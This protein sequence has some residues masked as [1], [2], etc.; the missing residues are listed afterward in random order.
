MTTKLKG[1]SIERFRYL[2]FDIDSKAGE[3]QFHYA[4]DD[5]VA[6]VEKLLIGPYPTWDRPAVYEA[7]RLVYL[8]SGVS[9]YKAAAPPILDL[10][11]ISLRNGEPEFLRSFYLHGLGEFAFRNGLDL[12]GLTVEAESRSIA[13]SPTYGKHGHPLIPFGGGID[14][15]VSVEAVRYRFPNSAL[16]IVSPPGRR[17]SAIEEAAELTGLPVVRAQRSIDPILR[18]SDRLGFRNGH[19]PI[20]GIISAIAVLL[21]MLEDRDAVI[22]SNEWSASIGNA[23]VDGQVVNHQYSK[24][25]E[26]EIEFRKVLGNLFSPTIEYFSLLRSMSAPAIARRFAE[27]TSYHPVFRSC[28]RAF[29]IDLE[30]RLDRWCARCDK[31]CFVDLMLAPFMEADSLRNIFDGKEP[32]ENPQLTEQ[33]RT[34]LGTSS[35]PKPFECVGDIQE[36]RGAVAMAAQRSDRA[37]NT[38]LASLA[39][40]VAA[41]EGAN[42]NVLMSRMGPDMIPETYALDDLLV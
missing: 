4:L 18:S 38:L 33:F 5:K 36:C 42:P 23:E 11:T 24:S 41:E 35:Q 28:N 8:L 16:C 15:I 32:L 19:V 9:Y 6:F 26:F 27:L 3:L 7:A 37:G 2:G 21:A 20:T 39:N 14:S 40:E 25:L 12:S 30:Q 29:H 34:L 31:C 13:R 22:M 10:G 1:N 17:F